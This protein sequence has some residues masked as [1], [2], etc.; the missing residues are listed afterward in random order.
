MTEETTLKK[1]T[2]GMLM[3]AQDKQD[4]SPV[5]RMCEK[6]EETIARVEYKNW[7]AW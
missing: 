7:W 5:C 1:E 4:V 6:R 2:E 3:A